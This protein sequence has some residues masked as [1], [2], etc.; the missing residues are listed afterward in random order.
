M[1]IIHHD[2]PLYTVVMSD[3]SSSMVA[4]GDVCDIQPGARINRDTAIAGDIPVYG[5]RLSPYDFTTTEP[6]RTGKSLVI[7]QRG[8]PQCVRVVDVPFFLKDGALT[9]HTKNEE[10]LF[11]EY[12][13]Q[14][15]LA[16]QDQV[17]KLGKSSIV[18]YV[19]VKQL[20]ALNISLPQAF[21]MRH[22]FFIFV[23]H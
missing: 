2:G 22:Q 1:D 5:C 15:M 19:S 8:G 10:S 18:K 23:I 4:L 17:F 11:S 20:Q 9:L 12:L 6:N 3:V 7:R 16:M 14:V 13:N 21:E